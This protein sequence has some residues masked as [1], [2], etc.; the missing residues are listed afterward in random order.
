[1]FNTEVWLTPLILLPGVALLL[2]ST[3]ARFAAMNATFHRLLREAVLSLH[4]LRKLR[5]E[6]ELD[7]G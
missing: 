1:M 7:E 6:L 3:S 5:H 2:V 4:V